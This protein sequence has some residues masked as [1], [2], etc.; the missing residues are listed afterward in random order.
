MSGIRLF[1]R[2]GDQELE[3]VETESEDDF[4]YFR[5]SIHAA[6][7]Q[8]EFGSRF[9]LFM[10]RF[11]PNEWKPEELDHLN[12]ELKTIAEAFKKLPPKPLDSNWA[13]KL[14][15]SG[16]RCSSL[17]EVYVDTEGKPLLGRLITLCAVARNASKPIAIE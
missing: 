2:D 7:E 6:L 17:F 5:D 1:V 4:H 12:E 3:L 10:K 8:G 11:E 16:R 13:S 9:P 15:R 14:H